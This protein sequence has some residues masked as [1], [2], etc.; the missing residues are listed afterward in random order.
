MTIAIAFT[1]LIIGFIIYIWQIKQPK[2]QAEKKTFKS[3][4]I[5]RKSKN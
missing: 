2:H 4:G 3:K 1:I 5:T